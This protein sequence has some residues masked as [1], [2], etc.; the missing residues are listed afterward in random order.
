MGK[1]ASR[2]LLL[3]RHAKSDWYS[4]AASEFERPLNDRGRKE[5][6]R[7][8]AWLLSQNL[9][10]DYL[11]SSPATRARETILAVADQLGIGE[12]HIQWDDRL[13]MADPDILLGILGEWK[14]PYLTMSAEYEASTARLFG[15]FLERG[16]HAGPHTWPT[17][18]LNAQEMSE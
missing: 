2:E 13:Y 12:R 10:P 15:K 4:G 7:M 5:A 1:S 17:K 8:G 3:L 6:P 14:T 16:L 9:K 18:C 11:V